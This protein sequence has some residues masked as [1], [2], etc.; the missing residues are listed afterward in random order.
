M[1]GVTRLYWNTTGT[2]VVTGLA[3]ASGVYIK[4]DVLY[5]SDFINNTIVKT[6]SPLTSSFAYSIVVIITGISFPY[7]PI[8][9]SLQ[10]YMYIPD[11]GQDRVLKM[12][13]AATS[14]TNYQI[15]AGV[16]GSP[17]ISLNALYGPCYLAFD[18]TES[19][20]YVSDYGN[21]RI[22]Q[23]SVTSTS[24]TAGT[25][26]A[27]NSGSGGNSATQLYDNIGIYYDSISNFLYV[28]NFAGH[29][30]SRWT[31]GA[32][33]GTFVIGTPGIPGAGSTYLHNSIMVTMDRY[34]NL[35]VADASNSRVM[36]YCQGTF[37]GVTSSSGIPILNFTYSPMGIAFDSLMNIYVAD[38]TYGVWK[39]LKL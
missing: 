27:G 28:S 23:F 33:T 2:L 19:N 35:Y 18:S 25:L 7:P 11:Q 8:I 3:G 38:Y 29:T 17:S 31:P 10:Q 13:T 24:G 15:L 37:D 1:V 30:V 36:L 26:V 21:S 9:D 4:N 32:T 22:L 6:T 12:S 14:T 16:T 5:I 39:Y 34:R 20:I